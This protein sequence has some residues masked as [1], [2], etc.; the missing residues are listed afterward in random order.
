MTNGIT[1]D[2]ILLRARQ[3]LQLDISCFYGYLFSHLLM[4]VGFLS[5]SHS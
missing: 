2:N 4:L 3:R 5:S 1:N